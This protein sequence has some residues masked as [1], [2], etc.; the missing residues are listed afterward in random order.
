MFFLFYLHGKGVGVER[1]EEEG[2]ETT[3]T[4]T[5]TTTATFAHTLCE[6]TKKGGSGFSRLY[7]ASSR[8]KRTTFCLLLFACT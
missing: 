6:E 8:E 5:T 4:I 1:N 3:T 7:P 2:G